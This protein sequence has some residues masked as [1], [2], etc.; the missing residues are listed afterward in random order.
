MVVL[1]ATGHDGDEVMV[2]W[3][4]GNNVTDVRITLTVSHL[5]GVTP[6]HTASEEMETIYFA[7]TIHIRPHYFM[8]HWSPFKIN[9]T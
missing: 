2:T 1:L 9:F 6:G 4:N 3:C 7:E 5:P 8:G